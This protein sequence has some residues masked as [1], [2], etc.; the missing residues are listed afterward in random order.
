MNGINDQCFTAAH[1]AGVTMANRP[2]DRPVPIPRDL[3]GVVIF[4]HGVNDPGAAFSTVERGLCQGLNERLSR[5][6][7][8]PGEYGRRYASAQA[9]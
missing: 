9:A 5:S 1:G 6:D 7:L 8:R 2:G 4:I 3:P